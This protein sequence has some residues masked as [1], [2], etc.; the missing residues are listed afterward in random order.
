MNGHKLYQHLIGNLSQRLGWLVVLTAL[1]SAVFLSLLYMQGLSDLRDLTATHNRLLLALQPTALPD[2]R[3]ALLHTNLQGY[4]LSHQSPPGLPA[5]GDR[6]PAAL[7]ELPPGQAHRFKA[8]DGRTHVV[9]AARDGNRLRYALRD[10]SAELE[11]HQ[12]RSLRLSLYWLGFMLVLTALWVTQCRRLIF[13]PLRRIR[14]MA[15]AL[16]YGLEPELP[17][18]VGVRATDRALTRVY[19]TGQ[20]LR[21]QLASLTQIVERQRAMLDATPTALYTIAISRDNTHN[22]VSPAIE[23]ILGD[24]PRQFSEGLFGFTRHIHVDDRRRVYERI[25]TALAARRGFS[26]DYRVRLRNGNTRYV[27]NSASLLLDRNGNPEFI[28]GALTDISDTFARTESLEM[29]A[30]VFTGTR[31]GVMITDTRQT[32]LAVNH[33]FCEITGY[34]EAELRAGGTQLL[35]SGR[36]NDT[37]FR[38]M[39]KHLSRHGW[40]R[41][42]IWNR[43]KTGEIYPELLTIT[44]WK[45]AKGDVLGFIGVFSDLTD[46]GQAR[47]SLRQLC[48]YDELTGLPNRA[49]STQR[50]REAVKD[51]RL[52]GTRPAVLYIDLDRFKHV[53]DTLGHKAGDQALTLVGERFAALLGEDAALSRIN[54]DEFLVLIR[55]FDDKKDVF[56]LA[57]TLLRSLERPLNIAGVDLKIAASIGVALYPD[58]GRRASSLMKNAD[59][60]M[61]RAKERGHN[62]WQRFNDA[63]SLQIMERAL[64]ENYL[65][66]AID[67][68]QVGCRFQPEID[69]RTGTVCAT[70]VSLRWV[71]PQLGQVAPEQFLPIAEESGL[72]VDL[73]RRMFVEATAAAAEWQQAGLQYGRLCLPLTKMELEHE[74]L[75]GGIRNRLSD[76]NL[77]FSIL[78]LC[79]DERTLARRSETARATLDTLRLLNMHITVDEFGHDATSLTALRRF[80]ISSVRITPQLLM[81]V[82]TDRDDAAVCRA[83]CSMAR[84]LGFPVSAGSIQTD[85]QADFLYAEGCFQISGELISQ[86]LPAGDYAEWLERHHDD[87]SGGFGRHRVSGR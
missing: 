54:G 25:R 32:I 60:A 51:A 14:S 39:F 57:E 87:D 80:P 9:V 22:Y 29:L 48:H 55:H 78:D 15:R 59:I 28:Q 79:I 26:V 7:R 67:S 75:S 76:L 49:L 30:A 3:D 35:S 63:L 65:R 53:N 34:S 47:E 52:H 66:E 16:E 83:I 82:T 50:L 12:Q 10:V 19:R 45:N 68:G 43:R 40:W 31:D 8:R 72:I 84:S 56:H 4:V 44:E 11:L 1:P 46:T 70:R 42:E 69:L 85:A 71:H 37:Y 27:R 86:P 20:R 17:E 58:D 18:A 23:Q 77:P 41:G 24:R 6:L 36:H 38:Q 62:C 74:N 33:S 13:S 21:Q 64:L 73:G 5:V 61:Y 81:H 2:E